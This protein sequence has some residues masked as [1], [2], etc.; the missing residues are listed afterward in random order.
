VSRSHV[1]PRRPV[2]YTSGVQ[3]RKNRPLGPSGRRFNQTQQLILQSIVLLDSSITLFFFFNTTRI[4]F[5]G[6]Y[7]HPTVQHASGQLCVDTVA[8]VAK[9]SNMT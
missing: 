3:Q 2:L 7:T 8:R 1:G 5:L 4:T 6:E 9:R